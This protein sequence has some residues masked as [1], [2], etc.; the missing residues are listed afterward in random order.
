MCT[1]NPMKISSLNVKVYGL[2]GS[3]FS[4]LKG[5]VAGGNPALTSQIIF[6]IYVR[7]LGF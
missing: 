6:G 5:H 1:V 4:I 3:T 7:K 2:Q